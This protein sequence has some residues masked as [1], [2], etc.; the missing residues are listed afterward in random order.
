VFPRFLLFNKVFQIY[1]FS[2]Q[3]LAIYLPRLHRKYSAGSLCRWTAFF[4]LFEVVSL[5]AVPVPTTTVN[6][7]LFLFVWVFFFFLSLLLRLVVVLL[8]WGRNR[9][10][11]EG[12]IRRLYDDNDG[13]AGDRP[14]NCFGFICFFFS[15][16]VSSSP[17]S[18]LWLSFRYKKK[19][20]RPSSSQKDYNNHNNNE[21][22]RKKR[23]R[24]KK[25]NQKEEEI[26]LREFVS[27]TDAG[28]HSNVQVS[29][30]I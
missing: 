1:K 29:H 24:R 10:E 7:N 4:L 27:I 17:A 30:A 8:H 14:S 18:L 26:Q 12:K 9:R 6:R 21:K 25:T 13:D 3:H 20:K 19:L 23:R 2:I 15:S 28:Y 11:E 16:V 22:K 5:S